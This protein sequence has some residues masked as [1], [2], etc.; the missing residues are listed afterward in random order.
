M[1]GSLVTFGLALAVF[2]V[3]GLAAVENGQDDDRATGS[4]TALVGARRGDLQGL[5]ERL[6]QVPKDDA[7]W[8]SLGLAYIDKAKAT[9][10]P[11]YYPKAEGALRRSLALRKAD[12]FVAAAGMAALANARHDFAAAREWARK[13]LA[14]NPSNPTLYGTLADAETQLGRYPEAFEATQR[15][16]DISPDTA[17][18]A[19][20]SYSW[21]LRGDLEQARALMERTLDNAL[22]PS[23]GAFARYHLGDLALLAGDPAG[24]LAHYEAGLRGAPSYSPLLEGRARAKLALGLA[25]DAAADMADAVSRMPEPA[26]VLLYGELLES[27][28]RTAEADQQY[29]LFRAEQRLFEANGVVVDVE[30]ALFES[31]HGDP[32]R[33]V[34]VAEAGLRSRPFMDMQDAYG[35]ALHRAGRHEEALAAVTRARALGTKNPLFEFH[36]GMIQR[37]LGRTEPARAHL[38]AALAMNPAFHPLHS[39]T[40]LAALAEMSGG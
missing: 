28:G 23:Q 17:S 2:V 16:V 21:E 25:E 33:A 8:A 13:G 4:R 10:N 19:R 14:I 5:Q 24:A 3:G 27:L 35:W 32:Q 31:D 37:S 12:N 30:A 7:A 9:A 15:M 22:T 20:V 36:A 40:A 34:A 29:E 6:R 1:V 11:E 18:L 39:R 38:T 26:Y